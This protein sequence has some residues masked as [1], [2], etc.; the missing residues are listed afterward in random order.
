[1]DGD[2]KDIQA[3]T[4]RQWLVENGYSDVAQMIDEIMAKW[5]T[6]GKKTRR[7]WWEVLAGDK[8]GNPRVVEGRKFPVIKAARIRQQLKPTAGCISRHRGEKALPILPQN[9]WTRSA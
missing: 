6:A 5:K 4:A 1:M 3:R 8:D 2:S 9:R 7:D